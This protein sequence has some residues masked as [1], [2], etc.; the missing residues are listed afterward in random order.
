ML[1]DCLQDET[2]AIFTCRWSEDWYYLESETKQKRKTKSLSY[3]PDQYWQPPTH[4]YIHWPCS[5]GR[6]NK[7][8]QSFGV[9]YWPDVNWKGLLGEM[10]SEQ[11]MCPLIYRDWGR[12]WPIFMR[13]ILSKSVKTYPSHCMYAKLW[14][15]QVYMERWCKSVKAHTTY[16][17]IENM[18]ANIRAVREPS[19]SHGNIGPLGMILTKDPNNCL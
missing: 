16:F 2:Q 1:V 5:H 13:K 17:W 18:N 8:Q 10:Y 9:E 6:N 3:D 7:G 14:L 4:L 15:Y 12:S 11:W 19:A